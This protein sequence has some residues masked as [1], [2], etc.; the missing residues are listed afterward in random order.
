MSL[1]LS[2]GM[3]QSSSVGPAQ[4]RTIGTVDLSAFTA[5]AHADAKTRG[6]QASKALVAALHDYGF[7]K[8]I[9]HGISNDEIREALDWTQKLFSLPYD[10]KMKAPH[11]PG[12]MPH[13]GYSGTGK[14]KVYSKDD[15]EEFKDGN[16]DVGKN[17][18]KISDYKVRRIMDPTIY[19]AASLTGYFQH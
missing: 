19:L 3:A 6:L 4:A 10:D 17:L 15:V 18:R 12:P 1:R 9:G 2:A 16:G 7:V 13:R 5:G 8:V 11:P 14:E